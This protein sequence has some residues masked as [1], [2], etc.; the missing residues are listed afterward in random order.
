MSGLR[1]ALA[2]L[3]AGIVAASLRRPRSAIAA[4][5]ALVLA[6]APGLLLLQVRTDG[7]LLVPEADP[8]VRYDR[9]VA[10]HFGLRDP[11]VVFLDT[12]RADGLYDA[13]FLRRLADLTAALQ[14][15][16]AIGERHVVSLATE[17]SDRFANNAFTPRRLLDPL[18]DTPELLVRLRRDLATIG[19]L[20]GTLVAHD[21]SGATLLVGVPA[22]GDRTALVGEVERLAREVVGDSAA[23]HVVGAPV[24]EALLGVH[25]L[26][27]L[28]LLV[29]LSVALIAGVVFWFC[30]R[31]A[32]VLLAMGKIGACLLFVFG[33]MGVVGSPVYLTTAIL[34]VMLVTLGLADEIHLLA[35]YQQRLSA[36]P[37]PVAHT[38]Q[39]MTRAIVLT[40]ITTAAGF[41]SFLFSDL[42]P[43]RS[44]GVFAP[45]GILFCLLWTLVA[46]PA[47]L[48]LLGPRAMVR[49]EAAMARR[50]R[51]AHVFAQR[52]R[53]HAAALRLLLAG[54][55][56]AAAFGC[57]RL[58]VQDSW[59]DGF[60]RG[61]AFR[62]STDLVNRKLFGTHTLLLVL[63]AEQPEGQ[64][65]PRGLVHSGPLLDPTR[66]AA[67]GRL[68]EF[69]RGQPGVGGVLGLH[70]QLAALAYVSRGRRERAIEPTVHEVERLVRLFGTARGDDRRRE[71]LDDAMRSTV[72]MCVLENANYRDTRGLMAALRTHAEREL[73][74]LR[75][76]MAFAGDVAVSQAMIPAIIAT[77]LSSLL[78]TLAL[79][80]LVLWLALASLRRAAL[81]SLPSVLGVLW[82]F[83]TMG[84]ADIPLAVA[85]SMF[86][87]IS[88][89]IGVDYAV[90]WHERVTAAKRRGV[91]DAPLEGLAASAPAIA[92]DTIAI[93]AGFGL[94]AVSQV[95]ANARLG[96]LVALA[97][98]SSCAVT[99]LGLG[100]SFGGRRASRGG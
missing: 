7:R 26:Q 16:P 28:A 22:E 85:T 100:A 11:I 44:L 66:I 92:A 96:L 94:L 20:D 40:S 15:R 10:A 58:H 87:A 23:V 78:L 83:G 1:R 67:I 89:G 74:P 47:V 97:L 57:L 55:T 77:Q 42:A 46:T 63:T 50:S 18:P 56:L 30:R 12:G 27:D 61:S 3:C 81:C 6:V 53:G 43:V 51:L 5:L 60:A 79:N 21:H 54:I 59:I 49:P 64:P 68:E 24:A 31:R 72:V 8:A 19:I 34:P 99:L 88:L 76:T 48:R 41:A 65:P 2:R 69:A 9:E 17:P 14:A 98:L 86:C 95:P 35:D 93:A 38:L 45:V 13:A 25:I 32:A 80:F 75:M 71:M 91:T 82:V 52:V 33:L 62:V 36:D 90:H 39:A 37:D 73:A 29:P 4:V 84:F 70:S